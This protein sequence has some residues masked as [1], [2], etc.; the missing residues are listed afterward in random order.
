MNFRILAAVLRKDVSSLAPIVTVIALLFLSD[1]L[2]LRLELVPGWPTYSIT[3][4]LVALIVLV[5]SVFQLDSAASLT[6]DWLCRP[7]RKRELLGAKLLLVFSVVYLPRAIGTFAADLALGFRVSES[8]LDAVL[9]HD[10]ISLFLL[11]VFLFAAIVTRTFVQGFGVVFAI[12][13]SVLVVPSAFVRPQSPLSPGIREELFHSGLQWLATT[14]AKLACLTLLAIGFWLVYWRRRLAAARALLGATV[15][16]TLLLLVLPMALVP[17]DTT[18]AIQ[19][20][21]VPAPTADTS[22]ITLRHPR[23]CFIAARRAELATDAAF[24]AAT[25]GSGDRMWEDEALKGFG[26]DAIAFLTQIEARGLPRDWRIKVNYVQARY[27]TGGTSLYSLRPASY[28][29]APGDGALAHSWMLPES[30]VT[31]LRGAQAQLDLD[32]SLTLLQPREHRVPTDGDR[33]ELPGLGYCSAGVDEPGNRIE[34]DCF[35]ASAHVAQISAEL[36]DI[37]AT[38][39]FGQDGVNFAPAWARWPYGKRVRLAIGSPR[40]ARHD[41]ITV[42]AWETGGHVEKGLRL[43]GILGA[44][45]ETCPVPTGPS[46][47]G[48]GNHFQK[49]NWRDAAAH[50]I[51]SIGVQDGVQ[52]E[53]LDFGGQGSPMLL[54]PGLGATAHSFDELAP[55]LARRHRVVALTRRGAGFSSRPDFGYDTPRLAQDVLEVMSAM[56]LDRVVLVGHSI[57]GEELTWLGG[58]HPDRVRALVYLDAA[59]DRSR[60]LENEDSRYAQLNRSLPPEPPIPP[61]ALLNFGAMSRHLEERGHVRLPEG[62]L[63]AFR[64]VNDPY[65]AGAPN[66]DVRAQ[67]AL[68][69]AIQAPDYAR[70]NIPALAIYAFPDPDKPLP[71]WYDPRDASLKVTVAEL[72]EIMK[73]KKRAGI[74]QFKS[75]VEQG[76]VV[77][78]QHATHYLIQSN[79]QQV[80]TA[81][82]DFV[83]GLDADGRR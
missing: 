6:D 71:P 58:H 57:A 45:P 66:I 40:L 53:V 31:R 12:Y 23:S 59:F 68:L 19:K 50:E 74:D 69:A 32:Y 75:G 16:I 49:A 52:L 13:I 14:P 26:P 48:N 62:E 3:V 38:R 27:S 55:L 44:G 17:W 61:A 67:Q 81:I 64:R 21:F 7:V 8:L 42:T 34:V 10:E 83:Q 15:C 54:L 5:M 35:T 28:I 24:V 39:A 47:L 2:I 77:E 37:P 76:Q 36:N 1:A 11:P 41:T 70:V 30:A 79:Q 43:P 60:D 33:H 51:H 46:H 22:L 63:I 4:V 18:I 29:T 25:L 73:A 82:D 9:L 72:G 56:K 65:L 20:A 80:V 78:L